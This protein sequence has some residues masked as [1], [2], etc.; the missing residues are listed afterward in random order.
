MQS[1]YRVFV[2]AWVLTSMS[3]LSQAQGY[4]AATGQP[5]FELNFDL[6]SRI[7]S[8]TTPRISLDSN[9]LRMQSNFAPGWRLDLEGGHYGGDLLAHPVMGNF[10]AHQA[11]VEREWG[12]QRL[13]LGVV[14]IPFG[15]YDTR[16]TYA[17]GLI[18]YPMVRTNWGWYSVNWGAP[19][20]KWTGGGPA[21]QWEASAF[22]GRGAGDWNNDNNMGGG[23]I[24]AQSYVHG[25]VLGVSR[26]DGFVNSNGKQQIHL[27]GLDMRLTR[28]HWIMKGEF[29][30]GA[31]G[32]NTMHGYYVD[33]SYHVPRVAPVTLVARIEDMKGTL[34]DPAAKQWTLGVRY[35]AGPGWILAANWRKN[36]FIEA[37]SWA[38]ASGKGGDVYFQVYRSIRF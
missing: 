18:D 8:T 5:S 11:S 23:A 7:S 14:R 15:I 17:S 19:G 12:A 20:F 32:N 3:V 36:N 1:F 24:R 38:P 35:T 9:T 27:T 10:L 4:T 31:M 21:L 30:F 28:P 25:M 26:W 2:W 16:E 29:L 13:Q 22:S 6:R 33:F 34:A 37:H